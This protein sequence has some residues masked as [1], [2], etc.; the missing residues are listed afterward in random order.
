MLP[1]PRPC[2]L[3]LARRG[4]QPTT[5]KNALRGATTQASA[6]ASTAPLKQ[7]AGSP[8]LRC[9][10][11]I[12][13]A[14]LFLSPA[15]DE[16]GYCQTGWQATPSA[17]PS[18]CKFSKQFGPA[19]IDSRLPDTHTSCSLPVCLSVPGGLCGPACLVLHPAKPAHTIAR[20]VP[21]RVGCTGRSALASAEGLTP[22]WPSLCGVLDRR[23]A[24]DAHPV[25]RS[26]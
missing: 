25:G 14:T 6:A 9:P 13:S 19:D 18:N 22:V 20:P 3:A 10:P 5:L 12:R 15:I 1:R 4:P 16:A 24:P 2:R 7:V 8:V 11:S 17:A 21:C 26:Q 23:A